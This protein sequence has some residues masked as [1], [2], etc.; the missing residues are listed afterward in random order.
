MFVVNA[1]L[2]VAAVSLRNRTLRPRNLC[3]CYR[4]AIVVKLS[5]RIA[6][7][8]SAR[9]KPVISGGAGR[10]SRGDFSTCS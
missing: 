6:L 1:D 9:R 5:R 3:C 4:D 7:F 10:A 8:P 2:P